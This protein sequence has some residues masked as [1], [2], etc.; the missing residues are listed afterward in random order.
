MAGIVEVVPASQFEQ[1]PPDGGQSSGADDRS[2]GG[3]R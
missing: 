2:Q 1:S 3:D